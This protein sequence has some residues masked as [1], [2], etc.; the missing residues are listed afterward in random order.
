MTKSLLWRSFATLLVVVMLLSACSPAATPTTQPEAAQTEAPA[1][2]PESTEEVEQPTEAP[3]EE[4]PAATEAAE[5]VEGS[6]EPK[7][8]RI[9]ISTNV[10]TLDPHILTSFAVGNIIDYMVDTLV[11]ADTN[12]EIIPSLAESWEYSEDGKAI[13]FHLRQ[14]VQFSD[15]TPFNAEAVKFNIERFQDEGLSNTKEPYNKIT[16]VTVVDEFTVT[17]GMDQPSSELLPAMSNTNISMISPASVPQDSEAYLGGTGT[18]GPVGSSAYIFKEYKTDDYVAVQR[19]PNYWGEAPYY[20]E[21]IFRIV[22]EAAT[23]ESLLLAGDVD[24]AVLPPITDLPALDANSDVTVIRGSSARIIFIGLN[25]ESEYLSDVRVRQALN[26]AVD[27][28]AIVKNVLLGN[29]VAVTS[30]MPQS[31]F[32]YCET[33][34]AYSYDPEKAKALLAE[35][36]VPEGTEFRFIS[37][38]GR[39]AQDIQVAQAVSGYLAEVGITAVP[40]TMD[41]GTYM[42]NVLVEPA[43][44]NRDMYLLGWAGGYPHGSHTMTLVQTGAFFNRGY[45]NNPELDELIQLADQAPTPEQSLDYY[46]QANQIVWDDAPWIFLYQQGYPVIHSSKIA[47]VIVLPSEK[48]DT[49]MAHP[50][51]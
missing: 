28:E 41:W 14:D 24:I 23:R 13:T 3:A 36:G 38:N 15:G 34:P 17:L 11:D 7:V 33:T 9:A 50:A 6:A 18:N 26:Y 48:F 2:Q 39:Y 49:S 1:A 44:A 22:P 27:K 20:D 35:A 12:G 19:N 37:S 45:Y 43:E 32:G 4:A 10:D 30:P 51:E 40:E 8:L 5:E 31:F 21:V 16:S 47:D 29:A 46:C 25:L 42:D